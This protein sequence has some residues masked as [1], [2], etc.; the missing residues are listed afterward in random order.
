MAKQLTREQ[1][2]GYLQDTQT[3]IEDGPFRYSDWDQCVCGHTRRAVMGRG[4]RQ[5][6][7]VISPGVS[8]PYAQVLEAMADS[9]FVRQCLGPHAGAFDWNPVNWSAFRVSEAFALFCQKHKKPTQV[10]RKMAIEFIDRIIE[11][12]RGM[13]IGEEIRTIRVEPAQIPIPQR[14]ERPARR[15]IPSREPEPTPEREPEKVPAE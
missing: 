1:I 4:A 9:E 8:T 6:A 11:E 13:D 7:Y 14:E 10:V 2:V 12:I 5:S 15:Q 3:S